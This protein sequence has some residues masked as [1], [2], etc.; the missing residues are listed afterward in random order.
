MQ[1]IKPSFIA[2][3]LNPLSKANI[4]MWQFTYPLQFLAYPRLRIAGLYSITINHKIKKQDRFWLVISVVL[5]QYVFPYR[6]VTLTETFVSNYF[7]LCRS[8][9]VIS[10]VWILFLFWK[11]FFIQI[12][13][14]PLCRRTW[15][16]WS[17]F[18]S[19]VTYYCIL[20]IRVYFDWLLWL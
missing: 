1:M 20:W 10:F 14:W 16:P 18:Q 9:A 3:I 4:K 2:A 7:N 17:S 5:F 12:L 15:P 19:W 8:P 13:N 6:T 11:H